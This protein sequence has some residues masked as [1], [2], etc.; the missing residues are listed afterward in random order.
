LHFKSSL[1]TLAFAVTPPKELF[2]VDVIPYL[3]FNGNCAQ[4]FALY[5]KLMGGKVIMVS[6]WS[7]SPM[8]AQM[9]A[10]M[11]DKIIHISMQIGNTVLMG[12]DTPPSHYGKPQGMSVSVAVKTPAEADRV[13]AG[14]AEGGSITMPIANT[15]WSPR[16]GMCVDRFGVPWMVNCEGAPA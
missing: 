9:P 7:D 6:K 1:G 10:E 16:F 4:A 11:Q 2:N 15:F 5:E 3:N 13:F 8:A 14:L 12:S